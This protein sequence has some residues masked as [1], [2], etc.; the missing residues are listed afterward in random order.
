MRS[1]DPTR[2]LVFRAVLAL[3]ALAFAAGAASAQN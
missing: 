3:A 2:R 1:A